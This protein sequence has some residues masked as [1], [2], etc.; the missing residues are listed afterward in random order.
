MTRADDRR[1]ASQACIRWRNANDYVS[2]MQE[3]SIAAMHMEVDGQGERLCRQQILGEFGCHYP[4]TNT[5][6]LRL[7]FPAPSW[8]SW[9]QIH[10]ILCFTSSTIINVHQIATYVPRTSTRTCL[11]V[12]DEPFERQL[13]MRTT[14]KL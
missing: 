6:P 9:L 8:L 3:E 2:T 1:S 7:D 4:H 10:R 5:R 12:L 13:P 11:P 14:C